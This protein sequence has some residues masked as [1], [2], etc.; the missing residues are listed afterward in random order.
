MSEPKPMPSYWAIAEEVTHLHGHLDKLQ[1]E[2]AKLRTQ[3]T[4]VTES[5]G[6]VEERCA[7]LRGLVRDYEHCSMHADCD[8]CEY[9]GTTST[10]CPLSPCFPDINELKRAGSGGGRMS[11]SI[12]DL[13]REVTSYVTALQAENAKLCVERDEWK[14]VAESKQDI[15]DHMRDANH[16]NAKLRELSE[17]AWKAAERLCQAFDGPCSGDGVTIYKPCPMGERDEECVYGQ[18]QRDLREL[19]V[20]V[21]G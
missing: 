11:E 4:D 1:A 20:E 19:G 13:V 16:E 8:R 5:M 21:D 12:D 10:H 3:L 17:G 18:L 14:R 6:R 2:N 9:D 15:I 7:R